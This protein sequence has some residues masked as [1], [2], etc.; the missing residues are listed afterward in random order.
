MLIF[1]LSFVVGTTI[2]EAQSSK[3]KAKPKT[4]SS[5]EV[6]KLDIRMDDVVKSFQKDTASLIRD[7]EEAGQPERAKLLLEVLLKLDPKNDA[8]QKKID[9]LNEQILAQSEFEFEFDVS[10]PWTAVGMVTGG[11]MARIECDGEYKFDASGRLTAAGVISQD[12]STDMIT[13]I[14][15][16]AVMA[17]V[18]P[19]AQQPGQPN[20]NGGGQ[21]NR[22][23]PFTIGDQH[24]WTPKQDGV[25]LLKANMPAGMKC[26]GKLKLRISGVVKGTDKP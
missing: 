13:G 11:K 19:L 10:K 3:A 2:V 1:S 25:L 15:L 20:R 4:V 9:Q 16:G 14:P 18:M 26:T 12:P 8:I 5:G 21:G 24:E 22:P 17:V 23:P 7:C 6:K